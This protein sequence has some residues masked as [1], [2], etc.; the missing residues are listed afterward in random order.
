LKK[1]QGYILLVSISVLALWLR[2]FELGERP[3]H[4]DEA[5]GAVKFGL[6]LDQGLY[7]YDPFEYHGPTLN[8]MTLIP[9]WIVGEETFRDLSIETVRSVVV[10]FGLLLVL[11][12]IIILFRFDLRFALLVS[13][14]VAISPAMVFYS[15]Y[16][17]HE[18]ILIFFTYLGIHAYFQWEAHR[19][20]IWSALL[21][22]SVGMM[23]A[24]KETWII[25]VAGFFV[26]V[27][28]VGN[29]NAFYQFLTSKNSL[30]ALSIAVT[31]IITFFTSF[32]THFEG[33]KDIVMTYST[34]LDRAGTQDLHRHPW[35]YYLELLCFNKGSEFFWSE[36]AIILLAAVGSLFLYLE[37]EETA[38]VRNMRMIEVF[39]VFL[40]IVYSLIPY[41][42]PWNLLS[43]YM[44]L[45]FLAGYG[46]INLFWMMTS[47]WAKAIVAVVFG[48]ISIHLLGQSF[49]EYSAPA[50]PSNPWVY[51]HTDGNFHQ[52]I[53]T[54]DSVALDKSTYIEVI[55]PGHGYW[56]FPWY[57]KEYAQVAYRDHVD[58]NTPGGEII[59]IAPSLEGELVEKLYEKP[60]PGKRFLYLNLFDSTQTLRPQV[61]FN[62][63]LRQDLWEKRQN[64]NIE[65]D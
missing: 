57:L 51:G 20:W 30:I 54:I 60:P 4:T 50:D 46:L 61:Y 18:F 55:F 13:F 3:M 40:L 22:L 11:L 12:P 1:Y 63:Y 7:K 39:S 48:L 62:G 33:L 15:R 32:F 44:G 8:Y 58:F 49:N 47:G 43:F 26:A 23:I 28:V 19:K 10:F 9:S 41:K 6:L 24:T 56:P 52:V 64:I 25:S 16:Y 2:I 34:Y 14:L 37:T 31:V 36:I 42:T 65:H 59:L 45:F 17:I 53:E 29:R 5:V 27:M 21:G 38:L 35:Y